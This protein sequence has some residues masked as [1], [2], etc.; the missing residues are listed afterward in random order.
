MAALY[1]SSM[2]LEQIGDKYGLTHER[3][4]QILKKE[5]GLIAKDG[6]TAAYFA[7]LRENRQRGL[8]A[9]KM[10]KNGCTIEQWRSIPARARLAFLMQRKNARRDD[11]AWALS[12]WDWW[13]LW[14]DSDRWGQRGR[15]R[16]VLGR[17]DRSEPWALGNVAI[18]PMA[19]IIAS[20]YK[21]GLQAVL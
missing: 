13:T 21:G 15:G 9:R 19:A 12:V 7:A 18:V 1:R 2:T 17:L 20:R 14:R 8:D 3:V 5:L 4:R 10:V 11:N 6:A 16:Y